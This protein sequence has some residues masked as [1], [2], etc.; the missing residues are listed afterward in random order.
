MSV[1]GGIVM[2]M[3]ITTKSGKIETIKTAAGDIAAT[4]N[5]AIV[6]TADNGT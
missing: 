1:T 5:M 6:T 3:D 4:N 2:M